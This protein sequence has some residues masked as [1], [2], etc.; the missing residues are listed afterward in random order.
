MD[1]LAKTAVVYDPHYKDHDPG[2]GH[3]EK[4]ERCNAVI[5]GIKSAVPVK[6][7]AFIKPRMA[8][9]EE[10]E[11][12]HAHEYAE[13]ARRDIMGGY[14]SL[15]TGDTDVCAGSFD[16]ALLAAGGCI[17]A[18]DAVMTGK[19]R[20]AFCAVRPPGH[21]ATRDRGMG[22][23]IF[24][25][26]AIA[27]RYA[28]KRRG[29]G[30]VLIADW[31]VHHGNGTQDIFYEDPSVFYFSTHQWPC[32]PGTGTA[33]ETGTGKGK[34]YTMNCPV[35]PG[36]GREE[37]VGAFRDNLVPAMEKFRPEFVM[38][39]AGFDARAGDRIGSLLLKDEDFGELTRIV[40]EIADKYAGGRIVSAL[41][42]G[43]T[44]P[45]LASSSGEHVKVLCGA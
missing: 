43:Y 37:I 22:F 45:G 36:S 19:V 40:M 16:I 26:I 17:A 44:L 35:A 41:E 10:I 34:G 2:F 7:V 6:R 11:L 3:P 25:N 21:H 14:G 5:E 39:S 24:N 8:T 15:S 1:S 23:C 31:D 42:G 33:D 9:Q 27:A 32:Y 38:I 13:T 4:P 12:C 20:N 28:Q 29:I 18:V 30:K